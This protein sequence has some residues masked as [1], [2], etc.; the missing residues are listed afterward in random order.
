MTVNDMKKKA[1]Y[2]CLGCGI[3]FLDKPGYVNCLDCPHPYIKW[4]NYEE[5]K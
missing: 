2:K 1:K 3:L 5:M 4:L